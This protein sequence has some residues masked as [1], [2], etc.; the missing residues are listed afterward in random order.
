MEM[1]DSGGRR[2]D[3]FIVRTISEEASGDVEIDL[4]RHSEARRLEDLKRV[5]F[6][7][8]RKGQGSELIRIRSV[9]QLRVANCRKIAV[10]PLMLGQPHYAYD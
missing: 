2:K 7:D 10:D 4:V 9:D 3:L 6:K 8:F 1:D 5:S